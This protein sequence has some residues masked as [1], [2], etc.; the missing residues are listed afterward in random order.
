MLDLNEI[1]EYIREKDMIIYDIAVMKDG[2]VQSAY[3][4]N[5]NRCHNIYSVTKVF[6]NTLIG[7]LCDEGQLSPEDRIMEIIRPQTAGD[8]DSRWDAVRVEDALRHTMGIDR[9]IMDV[10]VDNTADYGTE[11]FLD[12]VLSCPP[13]YAP[14]THRQYSDVAHYLLSRVITQITGKPADEEINRR[15]LVPLHFQPAGWFRCPLNYT[16]GATGMFTRA[17]D[18][19]KLGAVYMNDGCYE[20]KQIVSAD[21]VRLSEEKQFDL[22]PVE[23][24]DFIGKGGMY[25][26]MLIYSRS[27]GIA[28]AWLGFADHPGQGFPELIS[29]L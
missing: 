14:G 11:D 22:Y 7:I 20:G 27:R 5:T 26:Q 18:V 21:W 16:I 24:S 12:Y 23:G 1:L 8:Y 25:G 13:V 17:E 4:R 10:D 29:L 3:C 19:V 28:A 2:K 9:G 15:I 6:T